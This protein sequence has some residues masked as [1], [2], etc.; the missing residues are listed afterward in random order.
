M[1]IYILIFISPGTFV[2]EHEQTY[3][4]GASPHL[5]SICKT[6]YGIHYRNRNTGNLIDYMHYIVHFSVLMDNQSQ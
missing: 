2:Y 6:S 3:G 4:S 1:Y 5:I